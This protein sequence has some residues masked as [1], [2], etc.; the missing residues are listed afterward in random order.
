MSYPT[1]EELWQAITQ[2]GPRQTPNRKDRGE[3]EAEI[4]HYFVSLEQE[5]SRRDLFTATLAWAVP[6]P[7]SID[8]IAEFIGT[9]P[10]VE[11]NAGTG[12]WAALLKAKGCNLVATDLLAHDWRDKT[13]TPRKN[14]TDVVL[15]DASTA[16]K[17][18][19]PEGGCFMSCWPGYRDSYCTEALKVALTKK[20]AKVVYIGEGEGGCT[21]T[22]DLHELL[23]SSFTS[24]KVVKIPKWYGIH[25]RAYLYTR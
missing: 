1:T 24:C 21:G 16:I 10:T 25:D 7:S 20:V 5:L 2:L 14:F 11:I 17:N 6:S 18:L 19:M 12:L 8:T 22:D 3:S 9:T 4:R 13:K 23:E 15:S